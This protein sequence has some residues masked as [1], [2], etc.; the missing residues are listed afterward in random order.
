MS[1]V[2][3]RISHRRPVHNA[4]SFPCPHCDR[5]FKNKAGRTNHLQRHHTD[6]PLQADVRPDLCTQDSDS[7]SDAFEFNHENIPSS[8][9]QAS[10]SAF[11]ISRANSGASD[12]DQSAAA[13]GE[14]VY[15]L[16]DS[17]SATSDDMSDRDEDE[18]P[19]HDPADHPL[20]DVEPEGLT[21]EIHPTINV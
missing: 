11:K 15:D 4:R 9:D 8:D 2:Q 14:D 21:Q 7:E 13:A 20:D 6:N 17:S 3:D 10:D 5:W 18:V 19:D 16:E 1:G 12:S